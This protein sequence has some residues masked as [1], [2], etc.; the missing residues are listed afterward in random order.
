MS[1]RK[2]SKIWTEENLHFLRDNYA[3]TPNKELAAIMGTSRVYVS[4]KARQ[5]GLSKESSCWK[6]TMQVKEKIIRMY[7]TNS[8]KSIAS[9]LHIS[10]AAVYR[11]IKT[12]CKETVGFAKRSR[13][14]TGKLISA[15]RIRLIKI[16][17]GYVS[18]GLPQRSR[19][20]IYASRR[21]S[22][23]R[24]LLRKVGCYEIDHGS[25]EVYVISEEGRDTKLEARAVDLGFEF[26]HPVGEDGNKI[27]YE[28]FM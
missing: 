3:T 6:L 14:E 10:D 27:I 7:P 15:Y 25:N 20:H 28:K 18:F 2:E 12:M 4:R 13:E 11:F 1:K 17:K 22:L 5:L 24:C 21:K 8:Y 19:L 9:K 26:Y 16:E 23:I